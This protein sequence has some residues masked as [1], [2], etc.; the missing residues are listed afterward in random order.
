[1]TILYGAPMGRLTPG[2]NADDSGQQTAGIGTGILTE[3]A[4]NMALRES[5]EQMKRLERVVQARHR[6]QMLATMNADCIATA[7]GRTLNRKQVGEP[8]EEYLD[9]HAEQILKEIVENALRKYEA[10][11]AAAAADLVTLQA[12][13]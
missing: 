10:A 3:S 13:G 7:S 6:W 8:I 5:V 11:R 1:M 12:G 4:E 2:G 9:T